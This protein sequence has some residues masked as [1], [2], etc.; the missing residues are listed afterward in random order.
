MLPEKLSHKS[1]AIYNS[2]LRLSAENEKQTVD[3]LMTAYGKQSKSPANQPCDIDLDLSMLPTV[4]LEPLP[5]L[6]EGDVL[7]LEES[8]FV[9]VHMQEE[10]GSHRR[11]ARVQLKKLGD[12]GQAGSADLYAGTT[13]DEDDNFDDFSDGEENNYLIDIK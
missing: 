9:Q 6:P 8:T 5:A 1:S 13:D 3:L 2:E 10:E 12:A 4:K 7:N 11:S